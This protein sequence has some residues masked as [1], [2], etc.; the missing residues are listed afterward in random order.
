M[1]IISYCSTARPKKRCEGCAITADNRIYSLKEI[2]LENPDNL[3]VSVAIVRPKNIEARRLSCIVIAVYSPPRSRKKTKLIN[4]ITIT[5]NQLKTK[6]P[7]AYL[8][9]GGDVNDL[10][11]EELVKVDPKI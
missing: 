8:I 7:D 1:H 2:K 5:Y 4:F 10:K 11:W 6:Y 9:C 3:K